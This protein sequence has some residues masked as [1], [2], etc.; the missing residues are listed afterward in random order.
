M[1]ADELQHRLQGLGLNVKPG[2]LRR[3]AADG[4]ITGP[5]RYFR[6]KPNGEGRYV[7]RL[8]DWPDVTVEDVAAYLTLKEWQL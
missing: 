2:T 4:V 5:R 6:D 1:N 8:A 3:W 7:G